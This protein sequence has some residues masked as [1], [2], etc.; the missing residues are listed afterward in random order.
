MTSV[1]FENWINGQR[2][3]DAETETSEVSNALR[4]PLTV[5]NK[6]YITINPLFVH[7]PDWQRSTDMVKAKEIEENFN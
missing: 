5:G 4:Y 2:D 6:K 7:I 1:E 3:F